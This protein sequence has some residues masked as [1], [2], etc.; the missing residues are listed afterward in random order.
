MLISFG[1]LGTREAD[2]HDAASGWSY[3]LSC[4]SN[5]DCREATT[6]EVQERPEGFVIAGTGEVVPMT[7]KRIRNSPDGKFHW[8]AHQAG[9]D[10]GRTI[11][12]F[13]PPRGF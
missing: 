11:C 7:D 10:A 4:C 1:A 13:V 8:C 12:L 6:G 3:P 9:V 5:F 2:V